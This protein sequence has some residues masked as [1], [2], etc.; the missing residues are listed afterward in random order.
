MW[1]TPKY[2]KEQKRQMDLWVNS[3]EYLE[4]EYK[5]WFGKDGN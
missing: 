1:V 2:W 3:P 5:L 4:M